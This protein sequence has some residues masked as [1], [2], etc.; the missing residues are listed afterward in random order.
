MGAAGI[1][2]ARKARSY[3]GRASPPSEILATPPYPKKFGK[4]DDCAEVCSSQADM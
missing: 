1:T 3:K 2:I 4:F